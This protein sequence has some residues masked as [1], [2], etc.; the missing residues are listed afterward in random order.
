MCVFAGRFFASHLSRSSATCAVGAGTQ[1]SNQRKRS[2][3]LLQLAKNSPRN[4]QGLTAAEGL[5]KYFTIEE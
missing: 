4:E 1:K 3:G 2:V 5:R